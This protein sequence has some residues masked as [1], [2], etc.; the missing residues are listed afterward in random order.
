LFE[1][2]DAF[3]EEMMVEEDEIGV[4]Q[5]LWSCLATQLIPMT[6]TSSSA[7]PGGAVDSDCERLF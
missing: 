7:R 2:N 3:S 5:N 6:T 4:G 1:V